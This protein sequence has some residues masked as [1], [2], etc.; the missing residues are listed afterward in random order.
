MSLV[1]TWGRQ[2]RGDESDDIGKKKDQG[3]K[4]RNDLLSSE[5]ETANGRSEIARMIQ[6]W[7]N[8]MK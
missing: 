6:S 1:L 4:Q 7:S 3:C 8:E 2:I 5:T